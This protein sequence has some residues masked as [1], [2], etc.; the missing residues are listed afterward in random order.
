MGL[1]VFVNALGN[2]PYNTESAGTPIVQQVEPMAGYRT[3]LQRLTVK[4]GA[5]EHEL[6]VMQVLGRTVAS[7]A[8]AASQKVLDIEAD[9]GSI[10]SGDYCMVQLADGS[11]QTNEVDSVSTLEI[12]FVDDWTAAIE[13]GAKVWFFGAPSDDHAD[14]VLPANTETT[15]E[16]EFGWIVA[17][18]RKEP[19]LLYIANATNASVIQGGVAAYVDA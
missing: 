12:T 18:R 8:A 11:F 2:I 3:I 14:Y 19:L 5:T 9:P 13:A 7:A 6:T 1:H 17:A 10:A 4:T 16:S 15:Y